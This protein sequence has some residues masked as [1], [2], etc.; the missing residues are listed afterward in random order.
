MAMMSSIAFIVLIMIVLGTLISFLSLY[1]YNKRLDKITKGEIH[2]VH[3]KIPEPAATAGI[4]YK[5]VLMGIIITTVIS[6]T[7]LT[8]QLDVVTNKLENLQR[9]Q[10]DLS[11]ELTQL[12]YE[13]EESNK[14]VSYAD[15][16]ST[17]L[18]LNKRTIDII[19]DVSL[20]QFSDSTDVTL[21]AN[22]NSIPLTKTSS[23]SY[24]GKFTA[25][26]FEDFTYAKLLI[27]QN[28]ITT[29]EPLDCFPDYLFWSYLPIPQYE[30]SLTSDIKNNRLYCNGWFKITT[31][32][33]DSIEKASIT[34]VSGG[35]DV[36]TFDATKEIKEASQITI[37][38]GLDL[39]KDLAVRVELVT[40]EGYM[41]QDQMILCFEARPDL[42]E[43]DF[44]KV[45]DTE[46]NLIWE[47]P[48][49][50]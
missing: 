25:S 48:Y 16:I 10:N 42:E 41:I 19:F 24:Q 30:C 36:K 12:R 38:D 11:N 46:G 50:N 47:D 44:T 21:D 31:E 23:G 13:I 8:G 2:D 4:T 3:S 5:V 9:A 32:H 29:I 39:Q 18:D 33:T 17:N 34:Y 37:E 35:K 49:K 20:K 1:I 40:K 28:G 15:W 22:G 27:K 43:N 6:I 7:S 45:F 14:L 26:L